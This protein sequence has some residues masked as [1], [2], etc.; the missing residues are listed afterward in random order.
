VYIAVPYWLAVWG[1]QKGDELE[2][3]FY[4]EMLGFIVLCL[5]CLGL[6]ENTL[7]LQSSIS[8]SKTIHAKALTKIV[9]SPTRLFDCSS[10]GS[11]LS[12]F[13]KDISIC[14]SQIPIRL[15]EF[16]QISMTVAG[17]FIAILIGNPFMTILLLPMVGFIAYI[18]RSTIDATQYHQSK[19][20]SSKGPIFT[21]ITTTF[22]SLFSLRAYRLQS[23][24]KTLMMQALSVNNQAY[25][26]YQAS[27]RLM[28]FATEMSGNLFLIISIFLTVALRYYFPPQLWR[29]VLLLSCP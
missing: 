25:F 9:C 29:L 24:L 22:S 4:V 26:A 21:Q 28:Q 11:I 15:T 6:L 7:N 8:A 16:C 27:V 5:V 18:Y 2:N 13:S 1:S 23:Y 17:S 10:S 19:Y 12:R 20:L 3:P 14:D